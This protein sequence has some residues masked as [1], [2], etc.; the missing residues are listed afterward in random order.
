M[1]QRKPRTVPALPFGLVGALAAALMVSPA[2][3]Q[4]APDAQALHQQHCVKC[5]GPEVYTRPDHQITTLKA[6]GERVRWCE[7]Q[8]EL[9]WFDEDIDAV[10]AYVNDRFYHFKP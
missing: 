4:D 10:T 7:S 3:A 8:L 1:I 5:H 6:L 9:R 2:A